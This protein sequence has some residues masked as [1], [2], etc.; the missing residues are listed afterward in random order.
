[1]NA[2]ITAGIFACLFLFCAIISAGCV[3]TPEAGDQIITVTDA[4]GREVSLHDNPQTIATAGA[5]AP[6]YFAWLGETDRIVGVDYKDSN[7]TVRKGEA[8]PYMIAHPEIKNLSILATSSGAVDAERLLAIH[9]DVVFMNGIAD[10]NIQAANELTEKTGIPVVLIYAGD[11]VTEQEKIDYS[12]RL[13]AKILHTEDRAEEVI[14]Y[15][16]ELKSDLASRSAGISDDVKPVVYV[17]GVAYNGGH[18]LTGTDSTYAPFA[19]LSAKNAASEL[20]IKGYSETSK[21][22]ILEWDPEIIFIDLY[23]FNAAGG[24]AIYELQ[25]DP[26]YQELS[27]VKSGAVY[28]VNPYNSMGTNY[29]NSLV[30]TYYI[31]TIL[32]PEKFA[33]IDIT[34]KADEIYTNIVGAPVFEQLKANMN[35]L[36][37]TKLEI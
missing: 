33:D 23:T 17:G 16:A 11:Y 24:G 18:G 3:G 22:K 19:Q 28:G 21:E 2:K 14:S 36:S 10:T 6:R 26:S 35:N 27:A 1:M 8:R 20:P 9:P 32:Y 30:N 37:Y 25:T 29:E 34:K 5:G 13:I 4:A 7:Y 31:G 15:F 12:L